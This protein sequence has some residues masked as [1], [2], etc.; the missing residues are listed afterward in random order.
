MKPWIH[1]SLLLGT[2]TLLASA[3]VLIEDFQGYKPTDQSTCHQQLPCDET[4]G[5]GGSSITSGSSGENST[6]SSSGFGGVSLASSS[7][8]SS[9]AGGGAN[10]ASSSSSS[11]S[12]GNPPEVLC[13]GVNCVVEFKN[14]CCYDIA[15][16][17]A[18]CTSQSSCGLKPMFYC[19]G[20][21][22]CGGMLCCSAGGEVTCNDQCS[23][24]A[25]CL[26]DQDC[27]PG[28][29]CQPN[30]FVDIGVCALPP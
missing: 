18:T 25:V 16:M 9:G 8:S 6:T 11:S 10:P 4:G 14:G 17:T 21:E 13:G 1:A 30:T 7:S 22:D 29:M 2:A 27:P 12:S 26:E 15:T 5:T 24:V 19:D 3:C 28:M 23:G 20:R